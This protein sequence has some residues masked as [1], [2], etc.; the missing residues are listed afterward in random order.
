MQYDDDIAFQRAILA[1]PTDTTLKLVYAD[2]LQ[3]RADP[4]AEF[5]RLKLELDPTPELDYDPD[6]WPRWEP[7]HKLGKTLDQ[8]WVG[9]MKSFTHPFEPWEYQV[10]DPF[11]EPIGHRGR[12]TVFG[13]QYCTPDA[14]SEGLLADLGV[15]GNV[16]WGECYYGQDDVPIDSFLCDLP[17]SES[18]LGEARIL[19][20][21]KATVG[22][23]PPPGGAVPR[24]STRL[25]DQFLF[26]HEDDEDNPTPTAAYTRLKDYV[27][28]SRLW[29]VRLPHRERPTGM[30][31]HSTTTCLV[32]GRSPHGNR[33]LGA[34]AS[35]TELDW[36]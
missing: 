16:S 7:L 25:G 5:V 30:D 29:V 27:A 14:W 23:G 4:R 18:A 21:I 2:W 20:A 35:R 9:F 34:F 1:N 15:L 36:W 8:G 33:L 26:S 19:R 11:T 32:V 28:G 24:V 10:G 22:S 12:V 13:S 6:S 31:N 3:D 17:G